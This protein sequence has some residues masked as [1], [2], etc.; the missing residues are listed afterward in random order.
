MSALPFTLADMLLLAAPC[1][2]EAVE[3]A[4]EPAVVIA[5]FAMLAAPLP[6]ALAET[7]ADA[8]PPC[9]ETPAFAFADG[10][11]EDA[12]MAF[13]MFEFAADCV[14]FAVFVAAFAAPDVSV[15]ACVFAL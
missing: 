14:W 8:L 5:P 12:L 6:L 10:V 2:L 3:F 7:F 1:A 9:A 13:C 11:V 15:W 4:S